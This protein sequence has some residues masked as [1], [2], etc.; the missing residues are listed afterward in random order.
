MIRKV[1][2]NIVVPLET[3]TGLE[4][5]FDQARQAQQD[6]RKSLEARQPDQPA[7]EAAKRA[8]DQLIDRL[9]RV[10]DAMGDVTTVNKL[11]TALRNIEEGQRKNLDLVR[12]LKDRIEGELIDK[13][14]GGPENP[15]EKKP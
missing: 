1:R 12:A 2:D 4:G 5:A 7:A 10:I 8:L 11:I 9:Q 3:L 14:L 6:F 13:A 15:K